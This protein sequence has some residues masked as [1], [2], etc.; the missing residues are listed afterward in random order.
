MTHSQDSTAEPDRHRGGTALPTMSR[1]GLIW[2]GIGVVAL[3]A[4]AS[5]FGLSQADTPVRWTDVGFTA[6]VPTEASATYDVYLYSDASADCTVRALNSSFAEV[7]V[8]VQ[9]IDRADGAEQRIT[10]DVVTTELATTAT[11][12]Y[13]EA[14]PN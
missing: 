14:T 13:C 3:I 9:H 12:N 11:V 7:G 5:W 10:T 2:S 4:I 1:R 8:A 6:D